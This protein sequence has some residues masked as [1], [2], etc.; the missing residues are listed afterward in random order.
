MPVIENDVGLQLDQILIATDFTPESEAATQYAR[1]L[2]KHFSASLAITN[3]IDLS[4]S[5][6]SE[7][8]LVGFP[9]DQMQRESAENMD[10]LL[11]D[12]SDTGI[13][14]QGHILEANN[15]AEA[16]VDLASK[17]HA[18]IIVMGTQARHG[19]NKIIMGSCA[20][21]VIHHA[22][23]PVITLGPK[24]KKAT[25]QAL[26]LQTIVFATDLHHNTTHKAAIALAFAQNGIAKIYM[27]H[28]LDRP[29]KDFGDTIELQLKNESLLRKLIPHSAYEWCSPEPIVK[30]GKIGD[31]ILH[32]ARRTGADL[33]ILGARRSATWFTHLSEGVVGH[34]LTETECPVMTICSE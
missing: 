11:N 3:V 25:T 31:H 12:M 9:I 34:V 14:A 26:N 5:T 19:L 2:A 4:V 7:A 8:A 32:L 21:G 1:A 29:G 15:P 10:R 23:C 27:C 20:E 6:I 17:I 16:I 13:R 28:V 30:F 24:V 33:I 22:R 18:D